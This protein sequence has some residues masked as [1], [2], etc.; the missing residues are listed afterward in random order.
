MFRLSYES[1][2]TDLL[3]VVTI[4]SLIRTV[5]WRAD[6]HAGAATGRG[7]KCSSKERRACGRVAALAAPAG[8]RSASR[9][10]APK[11][12][13]ETSE[14]LAIDER[15]RNVPT[16]KRPSTGSTARL[17]PASGR[18]RRRQDPA[19]ELRHSDSRSRQASPLMLEPPAA[20]ARSTPRRSSSPTL[21]AAVNSR[22][23]Q[24]VDARTS[25][26]SAVVRSGL[27]PLI[28][29]WRNGGIAGTASESG[30]RQFVVADP[31]GYLLRLLLGSRREGRAG[32]EP[33]CETSR[34]A[35][36]AEPAPVFLDGARA[37]VVSREECVRISVRTRLLHHSPVRGVATLARSAV[38][39][40]ARGRIPGSDRRNI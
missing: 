23:G 19:L 5:C 37:L 21:S 14:G 8:P 1:R 39:A 18:S 3:A 7:T 28:V 32:P 13:N 20:A 24:V 40:K 31:D 34:G 35:S 33:F 6:A 2:Q 22:S 9:T 30:N 36:G 25:T 16:L 17:E 15:D 4:T 12:A 27:T 10:R 29:I 26:P 38:R 11:A